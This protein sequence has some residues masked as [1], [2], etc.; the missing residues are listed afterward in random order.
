MR[1]LAR[2]AFFVYAPAL[3]IA[4]H[5]PGVEIQGPVQRTDLWIHVAAFFAATILLYASRVLGALEQ[6][7]TVALS[8]IIALAW[9]ALDEWTQQFFG[10]TTAPDDFAANAAGV[11]IAS[12]SAGAWCAARNR[13]DHGAPRA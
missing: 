9:A 4:T 1:P 11:W 6:W 12:A 3:T 2:A 8:I 7:R 13:P 10:R 5:W